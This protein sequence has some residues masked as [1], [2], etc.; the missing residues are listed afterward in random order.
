MSATSTKHSA[1][2]GACLTVAQLDAEAARAKREIGR[3]IRRF[4]RPSQR[5]LLRMLR[6]CLGDR[7]RALIGL[8]A[9]QQW[10][11]ELGVQTRRRTPP[12]A[13]TL[14]RWR[15]TRGLPAM[16]MGV[17]GTWWT[18]T[19]LLAAWLVSLDRWP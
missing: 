16:R 8:A 15:A 18:T 14:K 5:N 9:V 11:A 13:S 10:F 1:Q 12:S 4:S 2:P 6:A 19:F 7:E 17:H 3:I